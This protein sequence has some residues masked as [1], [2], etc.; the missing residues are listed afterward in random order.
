MFRALRPRLSE[1]R[2]RVKSGIKIIVRRLVFI[3]AVYSADFAVGFA[4]LAAAA[5]SE[6]FVVG[7]VSYIALGSINGVDVNKRRVETIA[8]LLS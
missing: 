4:V 6:K 5:V 8:F 3:R 7:G 2:G 1:R